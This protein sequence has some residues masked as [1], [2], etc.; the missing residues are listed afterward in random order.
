MPSSHFTLREAHCL[1]FR[2][3]KEHCMNHPRQAEEHQER[4][5]ECKFCE[6]A[7]SLSKLELH[8]Q[9]CGDHMGFCS[10]CS[11]PVKLHALAQ[12]KDVCQ[13]EQA[14]LGEG[15][16]S[17]D[18]EKEIYCSYCNQMIPG[19]K[20]FYRMNKCPTSEFVNDFPPGKPKTPSPSFPSQA[21]KNQT[22]TAEKDVRPKTK[23]MNRFPLL[24]ESSTKQ[25][26]RG[27]NKAKNLPSKSE[28]NPWARSPTEDEAAYN[29]LRRCSQCG[30]L[31]P[32]PTL[33]QHQEKCQRL[34]SS[35]AKQVKNLS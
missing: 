21:A 35:K 24:Y 10:D 9:H 27:K 2:E 18:S 19:N 34:A 20:Y 28:F 14:Q 32:L 31:L 4:P 6:V 16:K 22:S 15:K 13:G 33:T 11:Q 12:H 23:N 8:E 25:A 5:A 3:V 7:L 1:H 17:L 26:P 30:I 29:I